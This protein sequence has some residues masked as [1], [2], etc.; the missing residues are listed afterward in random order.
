MCWALNWEMW[1]EGAPG[2]GAGLACVSS[3]EI[4]CV[5]VS[6]GRRGVSASFSRVLTRWPCTADGNP[7]STD[8]LPGGPRAGPGGPRGGWGT[9][10]RTRD[11]GWDRGT[12]SR[13][14]TGSS[15]S[16]EQGA[17]WS[18]TPSGK[19]HPPSLMPAQGLWLPVP[20]PV[21]PC[22][23][24]VRR[25]PVSAASHQ[26]GA[27]AEFG[28]ACRPLHKESCV[29]VFARLRTQAPLPGSPGHRLPVPQAPSSPDGAAKT[30]SQSRQGM[31]SGCHPWPPCRMVGTPAARVS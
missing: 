10:G 2:R 28:A 26:P 18:S 31:P 5:M 22:P 13:T 12:Q 23:V 30:P 21:S 6:S 20:C 4:R 8:V 11:P 15:Q 16:R 9:Q 25:S 27:A 24:W 19:K 14:P 1:A 17:G 3:G 29:C 7:Q